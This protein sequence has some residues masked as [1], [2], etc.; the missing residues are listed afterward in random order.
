M[1]A[2]T[3]TPDLAA[4]RRDVVAACRHLASR[5]LSPGSS[6]NVSVRVGDLLVVTPTGSSLSRVTED[7]L[8]VVPAHVPGDASPASTPGVASGPRPSKE[9]PL[10]RAVYARRPT[11][12]AVVHL[13]S[14]YAT[15]LACLEPAATTQPWFASRTTAQLTFLVRGA[16]PRPLTPAQ[17][18][19][20]R[21]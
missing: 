15:A 11:A 9:V 1:T 5:G 7:D 18:A 17:V 21:R 4:V 6:G 8:A 16:A 2:V 10:H 12:R 19:D 13:H 14:P 20:L 3:G